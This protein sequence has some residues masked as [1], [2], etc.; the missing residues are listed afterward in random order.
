MAIAEHAFALLLAL[1]RAIP[2]HVEFT[3][4]KHW[5]WTHS[6]ELAGMTMGILGLGGIGRAVAARARAFEFRVLAVDPE[7]IQKPDTVEWLARLDG[8]PEML[9]QSQVLMVCCP[10]TP[11]THKLLSR[12][13]DV[14]LASAIELEAQTQ[15]LLMTT[16]DHREFH[17]AFTEKRE[18]RWQGR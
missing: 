8:L 9:S 17:A 15:A 10:L 6:I 16:H 12:E 13:Q 11:E 14:D 1:T 2:T 18:P 3:K 7:P 4:R 5:E